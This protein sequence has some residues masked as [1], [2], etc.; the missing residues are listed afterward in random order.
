MTAGEL[1]RYVQELLDWERS[2]AE[3]RDLWKLCWDYYT[4]KKPPRNGFSYQRDAKTGG[5]VL[6]PYLSQE[7]IPYSFHAVETIQPR[8]VGDE[9][10]MT[11]R[12]VDDNDDSPVAAIQGGLTTWQIEQM[13]FEY[14]IR[15]FCRQGLVCGYTVAK[16]G[17]IRQERMVRY[18][19][20]VPHYEELL[21]SEF[22]VEE[23]QERLV[24]FR[25]APFFET[26][27]VDDFV[28]PLW[29]R[30]ID[31]ASAVWQRRWVTKKYLE[32]LAVDKGGVYEN[33]DKV[34]A[35]DEGEFKRAMRDRD[36][37]DLYADS[38]SPA[39][40][41]DEEDGIVELWE[42]WTNDHLVAI[43]S[44]RGNKVAL[45]D[46]GSPF[47]HRRKPF[48]DWAPIPHPVRMPGFGIVEV[49]YDQ[50]EHLN[51]LRRQ[52]TDAR[53][54]ILNPAW[55]GTEGI[56]QEQLVIFPGAY[57][58]VDDLNDL[59]PLFI[60][61][62][63]FG[64]AW[65]EEQE[66]KADMQ[67]TSGAFEYLAGGTGEGGQQ[68][69]TGVATITN[70][71]NKRVAEMIKV[72]NER[73]MKRVGYLMASMNAQWIDTDVAVDFT[74][75]PNAQAAWQQY[76]E[77][78]DKLAGEPGRELVN[79]TPDMVKAKGRL[80]PIPQIGQDKAV[81]DVQRRSDATQVTQA[82]APFVAAPGVINIQALAGYVLEQFGVEKVDREQILAVPPG[83]GLPPELL[84]A[85]QENPEV[86]QAVIGALGMGGGAEGNGTRPS[87]GGGEGGENAP[88]GAVVGAPGV[89]GA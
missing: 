31:H 30:D 19:L 34:V 15:G 82:L 48:V 7:H 61:Q 73:T 60:P 54:Y 87:G 65:R 23:E 70:E 14:E 36:E 1:E 66:V 71:G 41:I 72:L 38:V 27:H 79:V 69:A 24:V 18:M 32:D 51:T 56:G 45:R 33:V 11:Y 16:L 44:P 3:Q 67:R 86:L 6:N 46:T 75:D 89:A 62:I 25:N 26:V 80:E 20:E 49:L 53:T 52:I 17:W 21:D 39:G 88:T 2:L 78:S 22:K 35:D 10:R 5:T 8:V 9:P 47:Q 37:R 63:D 42:R 40:A 58:E 28:F 57:K 50:N 81:N 12:A 85:L 59:Q 29:A 68:T 64:S 43:A 83:A 74:K 13:G 55:K 76:A 4:P 84:Q 77:L